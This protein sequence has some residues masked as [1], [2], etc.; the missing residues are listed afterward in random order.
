MNLV[1]PQSDLTQKSKEKPE[2]TLI[3]RSLTELRHKQKYEYTNTQHTCKDFRHSLLKIRIFWR[4]TMD[5]KR[6]GL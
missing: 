3:C 1:F 4:N 2:E 5:L 6:A